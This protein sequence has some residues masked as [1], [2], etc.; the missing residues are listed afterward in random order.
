[1]ACNIDLESKDLIDWKIHPNDK[2]FDSMFEN[3][4]YAGT[5]AMHLS[6]KKECNDVK[7]CSKTVEKISKIDTLNKGSSASVKTTDG[8]CNFHTHPFS[9]YSQ[10]K[11]VWGWPS[12]ED[13]R[14]TIGF[15]LRNNLFH[16]VYTMEGVYLIQVNPNFLGT[17]MDSKKISNVIPDLSEDKGIQKNTSK[18]TSKNISKNMS[19]DRF[20]GMVVSLIETYFKATHGHRTVEYNIQHGKTTN[21]ITSDTSKGTGICM[22]QDWINF[23]NRFKLDNLNSKVNECSK[24]L[25]CSGT[26]DYNDSTSEAIGL[27]EYI[28]NYGSHEVYDMN[29]KGSIRNASSTLEK[30]MSNHII[31][32][33][34]DICKFFKDIPN[35]LSYG[36]EKWA[37]GQWFH[38]KIFY[39][40]FQHPKN[41]NMLS[42][43]EWITM[44]NNNNKHLPLSIFEQYSSFNASKS[45]FRFSETNCPS[46]LFK[47]FKLPQNAKK[48]SLVYGTAIHE[49]INAN[50]KPN[51]TREKLKKKKDS[52]KK[53][54]K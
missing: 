47:P 4:E 36:G 5:F 42:F 38:C 44:C 14:E 11:C 51:F 40:E 39:N 26:P 25:P 41:G 13:M 10:E 24:L 50:N 6:E 34:K 7:E 8:Y 23:A 33:F 19:A 12:G 45:G 2:I 37:P 35:T 43:N 54:T 17:L 16:L 53:K 3:N 32:H 46:V 28:S 9:C 1:M 27:S 52:I 49:W 29:S 31:K 22:P 18:N 21:N 15:M 20:R 30:K 48:C